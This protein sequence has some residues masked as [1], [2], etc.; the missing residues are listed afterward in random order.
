MNPNSLSCN[1]P[2]YTRRSVLSGLIAAPAMGTPV[3]A[4]SRSPVRET[5]SGKVIGR[6]EFGVDVFRGIPFAASTAGANR[7]LPPQ[8]V[9]P[10][11]GTFDAVRFGY[12]APQSAIPS[13][14]RMPFAAIEAT[15]EDCLSLN[16]FTPTGPRRRMRPVMVWLHGG[17]WR[18]GAGSAPGLYGVELARQG[19]V[20]LVTINHRLDLLGFLK[21]DDGD[22]RFADAGNAGV[23]DMI[24][25]LRWVRDN[26]E[27][28]GGDP[29]NV[30]IF[31]QSG[32]GAKVA[33]LLG[34]PAAR[35]L[36]HKA[37]AQSCSGCLRITAQPEADALAQ[38]IA[39]KL[40]LDR[41][42]GV[43]LQR[44]PV[45][46]LLKASAGRHRPI[47]DGR[48]FDGHPYDPSA[49][50]SATGVPLMIG[51]MA[52]ETR[53][54]LAATTLANFSLGV[55]EVDR[56]LQ[57]F[58]LVDAKRSNGIL[59]A[60]RADYPDD[61]PGDLLGE[62]TSDYCYVRNTRRMAD[63]HAPHAPVF[64]Y[65]FMRRTPVLNGILRAPHETDVPFV[66][67]TAEQARS[68]VGEGA[69]IVPLTSIMIQTWA[70]FARTGNPNNPLL[71]LWKRH[72][73]GSS[74]S[75]L[76]NVPS[77][78]GDIPGVRA[79]ATLDGLAYYEY[80]MPLNYTRP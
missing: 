54:S 25:A 27:A 30:T 33:A 11:A 17:A 43:T 62:I 71:P 39:A 70:R 37:I 57:K 50:T 28:F 32:G 29:D 6:T 61:A 49:A 44:L 40:G 65:M 34:A 73:A 26:A 60:Y 14:E 72:V 20:V 3:W 38:G 48:T 24:A 41:L 76:L 12:S 22:H 8:P 13:R 78:F 2:G 15:G 1:A 51:N 47:I 59:A 35:G 42:S 69:D 19:D 68:M 80:S 36:F 21:I 77:R 55:G 18:V 5:T 56:R 64:T 53:M 16:I 4:T 66:F 7:F 75:M 10:W 79:R 52:T 45:A 46:V 67:G 31:G 23:L 9:R 74:A 63:L 58:L